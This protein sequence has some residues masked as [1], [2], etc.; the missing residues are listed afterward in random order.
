[1]IVWWVHRALTLRVLQ[2]RI[3]LEQGSGP[4]D[5]SPTLDPGPFPP[6]IDFSAYDNDL[7]DANP[8]QERLTLEDVPLFTAPSAP[9]QLDYEPPPLGDT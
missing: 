8:Y 6:V 7:L 5:P 3:V 9:V 4:Q 2:G 1:M